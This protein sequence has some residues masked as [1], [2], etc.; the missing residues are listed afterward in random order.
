[1]LQTADIRSYFEE[2]IFA[3]NKVFGTKDFVEIAWSGFST[4]H[5]CL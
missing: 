1:M 2:L 3:S 4:A 5:M